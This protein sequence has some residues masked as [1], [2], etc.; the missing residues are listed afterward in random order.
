[1]LKSW[2]KIFSTT[3]TRR[4]FLKTKSEARIAIVTQHFN[5]VR[6]VQL[7]ML[8]NLS[9]SRLGISQRALDLEEIIQAES[10]YRHAQDFLR[11]LRHFD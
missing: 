5:G 1:M 7:K 2:V 4:K 10:T 8:V 3:S 9:R 6:M 11:L